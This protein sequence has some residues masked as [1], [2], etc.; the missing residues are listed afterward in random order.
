MDEKE[1]DLQE[2]SLEDIL[3]EFS[4]LEESDDPAILEEDVRV[5]DGKPDPDAAK[6]PAQDTV[7]LD[8]ITKAVRQQQETTEETIRLAPVEPAAEPVSDDTLRFAPAGEETD[9]EPFIIPVPEEQVEPYSKEWEPEYEQPI[10]EYIPPEPIVF[11]PKNRLRELKRKLVE[12]PERRYYELAEKGLGKLQIAIF[13]N[14][15]IMVVAVGAVAM[16]AF[17]LVG[18]NRLRL[19]VYSQFLC[20]ML[21]TLLG[22]Y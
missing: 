7:R 10:G 16:K 6:Q 20:M 2:F 18:D 14:F 13:I 8:E 5:W 9:E 15:L 17:G 19:L 12:G 11:R 4:T 21:S 22:S 1:K 3:K